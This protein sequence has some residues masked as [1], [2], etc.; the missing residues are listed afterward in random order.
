[1]VWQGYA[2]ATQK[3]LDR[4]GSPVAILYG[5]VKEVC[6]GACNN[7]AVFVGGENNN[8]ILYNDAFRYDFDILAKSNLSSMSFSTRGGVY[9]ITIEEICNDHEEGNYIKFASGFGS[10]SSTTLYQ[11]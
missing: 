7:N 9:A 4:S 6:G 5:N 2:Y 8:G 11:T 10:N 3:T 1:M